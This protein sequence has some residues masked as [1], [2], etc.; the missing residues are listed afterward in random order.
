MKRKILLGVIAVLFIVSIC[1]LNAIY[2]ASATL[3]PSSSNILQGN[4]FT[5]KVNWGSSVCAASFKISYDTSK[6][7]LISGEVSDAWV[8]GE[9][10]PSY[11]FKAK[12]G[13]TGSANVSLNGTA[14]DTNF[15][16]SNLS[17]STSVSIKA[18]VVTPPPTTNS[19]ANL[20]RLVPNY[21]GLTPNFNSA[22]T[23][24]SLTV[25]ATANDIKFTIAMEGV[26]AKYWI[27]GDKN[28]KVGDN[29]VN[30]TVTASDGTKKVYSILV[31]KAEDV[32]K[33]NAY[34]SSIVIDGK[35]LVP[36][37]VSETLE[38]DIGTV[39]SDVN[40]LTVLAY[41]QKENAKVEIIGNDALAEGENIIKIKVTAEDGKTTKEYIVKV[42]KEA[43]IAE[44]ANTYTE[45]N[46]LKKN[47]PS[48]TE[49]VLT[50]IWSYL[51]RF[52]L[53]IS[54]AAICLLEF[55][56]IVYLYRKIAKLKREIK[57]MGDENSD[58]ITSKRR[59]PAIYSSEE[60][61]TENKEN[62]ANETSE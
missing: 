15:N 33:A 40:K 44:V 51:K 38:Y 27:D 32:G 57:P 17:G 61:T 60:V 2:G 47:D 3:S 54:L 18:P 46:S 31:T 5:V 11:T 49:K 8:E 36:Q 19:N 16:K 23:K 9:S 62:T 10:L 42:N 35:T 43:K 56:Q 25:P 6:L 4:T 58:A 14:S 59:A 28:L 53:V 24:Y 29:R 48:K 12:T 41:A 21:E 30:I 20:K 7:T 34:L 45:V 52:W 55:G 26:G 22:I 1:S 37:F 50:G 13:V 39:A